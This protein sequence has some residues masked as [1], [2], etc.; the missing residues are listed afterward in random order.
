M[1][2][3]LSLTSLPIHVTAASIHGVHLSLSGNWAYLGRVA[4][5]SPRRLLHPQAHGGDRA[6]RDLDRVD[7]LLRR[8]VHHVEAAH[9][10]A[11]TPRPASRNQSDP[12]PACRVFRPARKTLSVSQY[13]CVS[14]RRTLICIIVGCCKS[15]RCHGVT[16]DVT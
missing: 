5:G 3:S 10:G 1:R 13:C 14:E 15:G 6:L 4:V 7:H 8:L 12:S 11:E 16:R 2:C 9:G